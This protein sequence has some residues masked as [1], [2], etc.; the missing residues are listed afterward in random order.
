LACVL[1][2]PFKLF[3]Q[4]NFFFSLEKLFAPPT[5][6]PKKRKSSDKSQW[7][8]F[9][10]FFESYFIQKKMRKGKIAIFISSTLHSSDCAQIPQECLHKKK[11]QLL[12]FLVL[13]FLSLFFVGLVLL[14]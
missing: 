2:K 10:Y 5:F 8:I 4:K 3:L 7:K 13:G 9:E 11:S 6:F 14:K 12:V 1:N